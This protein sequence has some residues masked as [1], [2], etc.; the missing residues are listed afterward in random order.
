MWMGGKTKFPII[1]GGCYARWAV[2]RETTVPFYG[3]EYPVFQIPKLSVM[4]WWSVCTPCW[5]NTASRGDMTSRYNSYASF[6]YST[7]FSFLQL[8]KLKHDGIRCATQYQC[9]LVIYG[10]E[11]SK[12][13]QSFVQ[14]NPILFSFLWLSVVCLH[15]V[16][17]TW[18][19][20]IFTSTYSMSRPGLNYW[21]FSLQIIQ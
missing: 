20:I 21:N 15:L 18:M 8:L 19:H 14:L 12:H 2:E 6:I 17:A 10:K 13:T 5:R 11:S 4:P 16:M 9:C 3:R 1:G 7:F